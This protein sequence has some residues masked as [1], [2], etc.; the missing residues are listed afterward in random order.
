MKTYDLVVIGGGAGGLTAAVGAAQFDVSVALIEKERQP[1]GDCLHTGC[2]PSK[3]LIAAA[4]DLHTARKAAAAYGLQLTDDASYKEAYDRVQAAKATIQEHDDADRL[5]DKGI[6]VYHGY[7][8]FRDQHHIAISDDE[9]IYGKRIVIATGSRAAV[10]KIDGLKD[11]DYLTNEDVFDMT[12]LPSSLIVIGAG[13][14]GLELSQAFARLGSQVTVM[15]RGSKLLKREDADIASTLQDLLSRELNFR[16]HTDVTKIEAAAEGRKR[17]YAKQAGEEIVLEAD[18]ILIAAGRTPNTDGLDLSLAG[19]ACDGEHIIVNKSLQT[20]VSH[21]YAVG[22]VLKAFPFTHAAGMEGKIVVANAV[23]GLRRKVSYTHVPWVTYTDPELFHLGMTE[24][25]ARR[26]H[27]DS[28]GV[29]KVNL[30][31]VDRFITDQETHGLV[32]IITDR[33]GAILGAHAVGRGA[34]DW[35]QEAVFAKQFRHKL[36]SLSQVVHPYPAHSEA[37]MKASSQYWRQRL[38]RGWL[39]R[40]M[41]RYVKWFR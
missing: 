8:R 14:V 24:E 23:F 35:M 31:Q 12:A 6:D 9:V 41:K 25:E 39:P 20:T 13:P 28:I 7:G 30:D 36:G 40:L 10:P 26:E 2:V 27:G 21:I 37:L 34:G 32:K 11:V 18:A 1:G 16:F 5:R 19:V 22:D 29:Y 38:V 17:V 4:K 3:A 15:V 33:R